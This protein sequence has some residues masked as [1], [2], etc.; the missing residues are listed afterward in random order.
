[1]QINKYLI[2]NTLKIIYNICPITIK[3]STIYKLKKQAKI[4]CL[5]VLE[6]R[7]DEKI[8]KLNNVC[9]LWTLFFYWY[10]Y[11]KNYE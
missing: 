4:Y 10:G 8:L 1:L 6:I 2:K 5:K 11:T 3:N 7:V 9:C